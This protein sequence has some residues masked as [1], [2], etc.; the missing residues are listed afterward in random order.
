MYRTIALAGAAALVSAAG[1]QTL[2]TEPNNNGSGGVWMDLTDLTVGGTFLVINEIEVSG[3]NGTVGRDVDIEIWTRPGSYV[4]FDGDPA[5]WTLHQTVNVIRQGTA[6]AVALGLNDIT[7]PDGETVA[8]YLQALDASGIRYT[9]TGANPPQT[10]FSDGN[11]ELFS[12][13]ATTAAAA[14]TGGRFTP[15]TFSGSVTY[16]VIPAPASAAL[17]GLSGLVALRRR[18]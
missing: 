18:R 2:T 8:V 14:F 11:L 12:D 15:R 13:L 10:T 5:G 4:G 6:G 9:G 16:T 3:I 7:I 1:A 17:L